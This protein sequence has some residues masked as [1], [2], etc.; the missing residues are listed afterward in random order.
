MRN[1]MLPAYPA[2]RDVWDILREETRPLVVYG[3]GNG[4]DKLLDA[5]TARG[6]E[7]ADFMASDG[8]V[9]GQLF[10]GKQVLSLAAVKE[11][12]EDF[13]LV[14]AFASSRPEV[15]EMLYRM[16][17]TYPL[18]M[19]DLPV[20]G[21]TCFDKEFYN[22]RYTDFARIAATF[23]DPL[24]CNLYAAVLQYRMTGDIRILRD[25]CTDVTETEALLRLSDVET[26]L[27]LGA[28]RG[29]TLA[30]VMTVSKH[31]RHAVCVEPDRR[32]YAKLAAYAETLPNVDVHCVHA[33]VGDASG[34]AKFSA[35]GNRNSSLIGASYESRTEVVDVVTVDALCE[36]F[37]PDHI[38]YDVE[39]AE[40]PAIHGSALTIRRSKPRILLSLYHRPED[41][42]DL[43]DALLEICPDYDLYLR[44]P[45]CVPAWELN[46]IAIPK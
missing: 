33:A 46:L 25:A 20:V 4:A 17:E 2:T 14:L 7:I 28:Y 31:L 8:F 9:R 39:G 38:K 23:R 35:S 45:A 34:E 10:H 5:C 6:I 19:P 43:V 22:A 15:L 11:K 29:D 12:Y 26:Y 37:T 24:S 44:R 32:T 3:M 41:M 21:R 42:I 1:Y 40:M 30:E 36:T 16:A 27:D 18:V 13:V